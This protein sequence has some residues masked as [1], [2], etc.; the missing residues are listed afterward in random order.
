M[1]VMGTIIIPL[2]LVTNYVQEAGLSCRRSLVGTAELSPGYV[3]GSTSTIE[4][5]DRSLIIVLLPRSIRF[6]IQRLC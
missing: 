5:I 3:S 4:Q 1:V 2:C 6:P